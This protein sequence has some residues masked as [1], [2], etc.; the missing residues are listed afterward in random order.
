[1]NENSIQIIVIIVLLIMLTAA[2]LI[3][4]FACT[5]SRRVYRSIKNPLKAE[6]IIIGVEFVSPSTSPYPTYDGS[7]YYIVSYSFMD[8]RG[9]TYNKKFQKCKPC[10]LEEGDKIIV[11]Y[12][13]KDPDKC[14]TDY[15]LNTD[16]NLWWK[17]LLI[18]AAIIIVPVVLAFALDVK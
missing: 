2:V 4:V 17:A 18:A 6:G 9:R 3:I 8:S 7:E 5:Q 15:R 1:M 16:K 11:Y 14:V 10:R 12:E 13:E